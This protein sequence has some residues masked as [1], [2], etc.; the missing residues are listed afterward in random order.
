MIFIWEGAVATLPEGRTVRAME[1]VH[2][3]LGDWSGAVNYWQIN[4]YALK[5]MWAVLSRT[6]FRIDLCVTTRPPAFAE[7]LARKC[8][9]E[10][11]PVRFIFAQSAPELG[12]RLTSMA[13]VERVIYGLEEQRWAFGPHG[14]RLTPESGQL[15]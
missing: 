11:W 12:R 1:K 4:E 3:N 13:D 2:G 15:V 6:D 7:A 14:F 9:Q 10:N 8:D 5:W